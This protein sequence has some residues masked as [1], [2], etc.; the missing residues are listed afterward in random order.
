MFFDQLSKN[1]KSIGIISIHQFLILLALKKN[2]IR[3]ARPSFLMPKTL[4]FYGT[5]WPDNILLQIKVKAHSYLYFHGFWSK[6]LPSQIHEIKWTEMQYNFQLLFYYV[7][8]IDT[9]YLGYTNF[10]ETQKL[11][12]NCTSLMNCE[13]E[14]GILTYWFKWQN[15]ILHHWI[16]R[17]K[18][19]PFVSSPLKA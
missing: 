7:A 10:F 8:S 5:G 9:Y 3:Q 1:I 2:F 16:I 6:F 12:S 13:C 14:F 18:R 4:I 11:S 19:F 15:D 17:V